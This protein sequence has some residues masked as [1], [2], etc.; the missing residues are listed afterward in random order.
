MMKDPKFQ[1]AAAGSYL[2]TVN[3]NFKV[4]CKSFNNQRDM[5]VQSGV[6]ERER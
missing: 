4:S 3:T 5:H 6:E 1:A 2:Q